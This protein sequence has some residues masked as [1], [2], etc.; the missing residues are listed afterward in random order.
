MCVITIVREV[1]SL[2]QVNNRSMYLNCDTTFFVS[3]RRLLVFSITYGCFA[4]Q[5]V[6]D[7]PGLGEVDAIAHRLGG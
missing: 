7:G 5:S 4:L 6:E 1:A 3:A 2:S